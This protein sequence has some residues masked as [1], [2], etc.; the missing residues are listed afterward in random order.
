MYSVVNKFCTAGRKLTKLRSSKF[1]I[2]VTACLHSLMPQAFL[3]TNGHHFVVSFRVFF[4]VPKTLF[5]FVYFLFIC[6]PIK[7]ICGLSRET[8]VGLVANLESRLIRQTEYVGRKIA[9]SIHDRRRPT[10][11]RDS[12]LFFMK[13]LAQCSIS[14]NF[15]TNVPKYYRSSRNESMWTPRFSTGLVQ[16]KGSRTL[17]FPRLINRLGLVS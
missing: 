6:R 4:S 13:C 15:M 16:S 14:N 7:M 3:R 9:P 5:L 1:R 11:W 10:M 2:I 12:F 17:I 8:V